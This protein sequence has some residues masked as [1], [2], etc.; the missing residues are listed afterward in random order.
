MDQER[1]LRKV[2][3]RARVIEVEVR[4]DDVAN[5]LRLDPEQPELCEHVV[6]RADARSHHGDEILPEVGTRI[7]AGLDLHATIDEDVP[8]R[9]AHEEVRHRDRELLEASLE[10]DH[11]VGQR[12]RAAVEQ[13]QSVSRASLSHRRALQRAAGHRARAARCVA[14]R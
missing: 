10:E 12:E 2:P 3:D 14:G 8:V 1:R 4:L 13:V 5:R 6:L 9:V 7:D 11:L